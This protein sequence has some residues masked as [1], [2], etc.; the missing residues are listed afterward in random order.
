M[1]NDIY[2]NT[3]T[4][5]IANVSSHRIKNVDYTVEFFKSL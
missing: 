5:N 3:S 4:V 1:L 2:K